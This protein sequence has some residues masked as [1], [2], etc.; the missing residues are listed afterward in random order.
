[1]RRSQPIPNEQEP[2]APNDT[3]LDNARDLVAGILEFVASDPKM[4]KRFLIGTSF[5]L[6]RAQEMAQS[7]LFM[8]SVLDTTRRND[9]LLSALQ[10]HKQICPDI[11]ELTQARL[12]FHV[13]AE[14]TRQSADDTRV[15]TEQSPLQLRGLAGRR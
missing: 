15:I 13:T 10:E 12:A 5:E 9:S 1:M 4:L 6:E 14:L 8:L 3:D 11:L 7:P 2:T